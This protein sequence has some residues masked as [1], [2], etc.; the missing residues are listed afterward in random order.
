MPQLPSFDD[1][2]PPQAARLGP[3][4]HALAEE[5]VYFGTSSW[6]YEGWLGSIYSE[7]RY[8]TRGKLSK[9]KFEENCLTEYAATFPTV[10]GDFA[11]YQFPTEDYWARL[12]GQTP[13]TFIV[14]LKIPE[15]I[16][17][18]TWPKHARYGPRAGRDNEHFLDADPFTRFFL[19][20]LK[21]Y[22]QQVGPLIF[23]FGTFN[24]STF[25]TA[26]DFMARLDLFLATL[27][28]GFRYGVEIRNPEYLTPEYLGLLATHNVAHVFNAWTRMPSLDDQSRL[29]D[30]YTAN[31]TVVRALLRRGRGYEDA[32]KTFEPYKLIQ[33]PNEG[34]RAGMVEIANRT[35]ARRK[36][37]F[38]FVNNRLEGNAPGTIEA[39]ADRIAT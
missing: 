19:K 21:P 17:V 22:G 20:R 12:F 24:K 4:L 27:P 37:A 18:A 32:V 34:A 6:K 29:D 28:E 7:T 13:A 3:K 14:G 23:E 26:A 5:G 35:R 31:F 1:D 2:R 30:A 33:E 38:L 39:V 8:Q 15:D 10:C 11:F 25:P 16:T 36:P 9:K